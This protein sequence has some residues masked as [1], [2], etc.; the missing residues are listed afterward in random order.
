MVGPPPPSHHSFFPTG[1]LSLWLC[2]TR[3]KLEL[4]LGKTN[5][6]KGLRL[7]VQM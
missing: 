7:A 5:W 1:M 3:M 6:A 4:T 2:V